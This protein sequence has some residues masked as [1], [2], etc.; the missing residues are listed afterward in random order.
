M[1][2]YPFQKPFALP[3]YLLATSLLLLILSTR[4]A[5]STD[6][7]LEISD[8]W[9]RASPPGAVA[10][11]VYCEIKNSGPTPVTLQSMSADVAKNIEPHTHI[12]EDGLL[13]MRKINTLKINEQSSQ[14][15]APGH[16]HIML[17]GL[18]QALV[19][20]NSFNLTF[21]FSNG[22]STTVEVVVR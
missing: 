21:N 6:A 16:K 9:A 4:Y 15:F 18:N 20:G 19:A 14:Q 13:K 17:I 11:A 22:E 8:A 10:G 7:T 1:I 3:C 2:F 12:H 5:D